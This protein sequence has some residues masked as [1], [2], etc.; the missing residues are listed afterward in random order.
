MEREPKRH[1][2]RSTRSEKVQKNRRLKQSLEIA[3]V[4]SE[5]GHRI[6]KSRSPESTCS[7]RSDGSKKDMLKFMIHEVQDLQKQIHEELGIR[8]SSNK[9]SKKGK[10]SRKSDSPVRRDEQIK[11]CA[12]SPLAQDEKN[13]VFFFDKLRMKRF[14]KVFVFIRF[15]CYSFL[16][17]FFLH[18]PSFCVLR[19]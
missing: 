11:S 1:S 15:F 19:Q 17:I 14:I 5:P 16:L 13:D 7:S 6:R 12:R 3:S 8:N 4:H 10:G 2:F 9:V 18:K